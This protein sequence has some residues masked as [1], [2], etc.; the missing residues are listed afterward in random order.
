MILN[1]LMIILKIVFLIYLHLYTYHSWLCNTIKH[2]VIRLVY[3]NLH[4]RIPQTDL[5]RIL[6]IVVL[7]YLQ[8]MDSGQSGRCG[9]SVRTHLLSVTN[10]GLEHVNVLLRF[11]MEIQSVM[12]RAAN[13]S[14][15]PA[16]LPR[17]HC[18][19]DLLL[20]IINVLFLFMY[21]YV[22]WIP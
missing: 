1:D 6:N 21:N 2:I 19:S 20:L 5:V 13:L 22:H 16:S 7:I 9:Q 8:C 12:D 15:V 18:I 10:G 3:F 14:I 4:Y 17:L 11:W